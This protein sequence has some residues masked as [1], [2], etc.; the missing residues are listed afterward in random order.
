MTLEKFNFKWR[1]ACGNRC[2]SKES[3]NNHITIC[4]EYKKVLKKQQLE[5]FLE[6]E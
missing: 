5:R 4:D 3:Y 6:N 2:V 1:C